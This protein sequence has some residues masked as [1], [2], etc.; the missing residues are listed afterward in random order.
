MHYTTE[1]VLPI[2]KW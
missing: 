1:Q 2:L